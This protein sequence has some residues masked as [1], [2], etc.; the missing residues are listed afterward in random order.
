MDSVHTGKKKPPLP[1]MISRDDSIKN[2]KNIGFANGIIP[3]NK[4]SKA[5]TLDIN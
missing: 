5:F 3:K 1:H 4:D 2:H